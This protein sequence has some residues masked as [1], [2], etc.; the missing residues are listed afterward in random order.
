MK[1][2]EEE[3]YIPVTEEAPQE[4]VYAQYPQAGETTVLGQEPAYA[5][6]GE[7]VV[8][9]QQPVYPNYTQAGETEVL[10]QEPAFTPFAQVPV[11]P[12][13]PAPQ[14]KPVKAKKQRGRKPHIALRI[15]LQFFSFVMAVALCA[16]LLG[17]VVLADLNRLMS[18]GGIQSLISSIL[19]PQQA[20]HRITGVVGAGGV[21]L[22]NNFTIPGDLDIN[23]VPEDILSGGNTDENVSD[24]VGW[25]YDQLANSTDKPLNITEEQVQQFVQES[26]FD[27]YMAEK[28]AGYAQD[29]INGTS[30]TT[31][32]ADEIMGLLEENEDLIKE[33]FNIE[34][35]EEAKDALRQ[36]VDKVVTDQELNSVIRDQVFDSV[37]DIINESVS[38]TGTSWTELQPQIQKLCSDTTLYTAIG[39]CVGILLILCLLN[40]YNV[41]AGLTWAGVPCVILGGLLT[42]SLSALSMAGSLLGLPSSLT[43]VLASFTGLFMPIHAGLLAIGVGLLVI[44][45]IWRVIRSNIRR[46]Q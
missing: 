7:T 33:S 5:Q 18:A 27:D 28:L 9:N 11:T 1:P 41:P 38:S 2:L 8:L 20:P 10:T 13:T 25:L 30:N 16:A 37:E 42:A 14:P 6:A 23:D 24:L 44:S 39:I 45:V 40:F 34:F 15:L 22:D 36:S 3:T 17:T 46:K 29:F 21:L 35:S 4:P 31:I 32:T 12:V 43:T 19:A 26:T